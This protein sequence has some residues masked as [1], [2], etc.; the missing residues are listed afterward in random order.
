MTSIPAPS[1]R[2]VHGFSIVS[3][4]GR[5]S[6]LLGVVD[7]DEEE[8]DLA[9]VCARMAAVAHHPTRDA[10]RHDMLRDAMLAAAEELEDA[11]G[12]PRTMQRSLADGR[13]ARVERRIEGP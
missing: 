1:A 8:G 2:L 5:A 9:G 13:T 3:R 6:A 7:L 10:E 11:P 4:S 12:Q